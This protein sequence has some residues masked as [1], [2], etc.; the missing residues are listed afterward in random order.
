MSLLRKAVVVNSAEFCCL[1]FGVVQ[2]IA[3]SRGLGPDGVG[4]YTVILSALTLGTQ[5]FSLGYP[6][7]FLY[8]SKRRP[9]QTR[10][11]LM[12]TLFLMIVTGLLGGVIIVGLMQG[13]RGYFGVVTGWT[14][15]VCSLYILLGLIGVLA[16]NCLLVNIE[17]KRLGVMRIIS[18]GG[19]TTI[20]ALLWQAK[21]LTVN[22]ALLGCSTAV[23]LRFLLGWTWTRERLDFSVK[24][25]I[26]MI[27]QLGPMGLRLSAADLMVSLLGQVNIMIIKLRIDDFASVGFYSRGHRIAMLLI[28]A[29]QAILPMLFSHW[30]GLRE[31]K[32]SDHIE[33]VMRYACSGAFLLI[34]FLVFLGKPLILLFYGRQFLPA[35]AP[36]MILLP[37]T[38]LYLLGRILIHALSSRGMPQLSTGML[39]INAG[40]CSLLSWF[41]VPYWGI[42]AAAIASTLGHATM[43]VLLLW[44]VHKHHGVRP[45]RCFGLTWREVKKTAVLLKN[46]RHV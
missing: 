28:A 27:K 40:L 36:M 29:G 5:L 1:V 9:D 12:N 13:F 24:P 14:L 31:D 2:S 20:L 3:L 34:G 43:F 35:V 7:S 15:L 38:G 42:K 41:L 11:Y 46:H 10:V 26:S 30:A 6:L 33:M 18:I 23:L 45:L 32:L 25:Q 37:G 22:T 39:V 16:R 21:H 8:H 4:Q 19:S 44:T 17:A